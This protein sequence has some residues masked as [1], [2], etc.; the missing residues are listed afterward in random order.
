MFQEGEIFLSL[1]LFLSVCVCL[2]KLE[3]LISPSHQYL[4]TALSVWW[5]LGQLIVSLFAWLF[6]SKFSC[7]AD[8]DFATCPRGENM[9]W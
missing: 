4:L 1:L 8:A 6:L 7:P 9:G 2:V 5:N 3:V